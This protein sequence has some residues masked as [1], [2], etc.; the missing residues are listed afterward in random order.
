M[1]TDTRS[2]IL[3]A[4]GGSF[5]IEARQPAEVFTPED[6]SDE[7]RMMG[8]TAAEFMEKELVPRLPR[9]LALDYAATREVL[10]KAGELGLLG[11]EI[12][13]EY[14][15]LGL[16]KVSGCLVSEKSARDG[17]FSVTFMGHIG[18]G[19]LPIVYFGTEEQK[20]RYLPK[21]ASGEWIGSYSLSEASSASDAMNAKARAVLS[22]DGRHWILN[23][24]KMWLTNAGYAD[25]YITFCKV[26]GEHFTAFIIDKG[27]PGVSLGAEEKK[28][29]L[30][31]SSTR[32]LILQDAKIPKQNLLGEI[33]K[34]HKIAFNILNVGR[35]KLGA[36]CTGA[37]KLALKTSAEYAK[38]RIAFGK[39]IAEFGLIR[40]KLGEMAIRTFV[41]ESVVYRTA[42]MI[43]ENL[44]GVGLHDA[45]QALKRIEE[46]DVECSIVKVFAS[47]MLD[48]VVDE[49]VQLFGG[50]GFVKDY[51]AERYWRDARVN[52][53]FE[54]TNE[55]NRLLIP[56]RLLRRVRRNE[57]DLFGA[58]PEPGGAQGPLAAERA[59]LAAIKRLACE[60]LEAADQR[61][62]ETLDDQQEAL[63]AFADLA[64]EAY[65][66]ES[67][68]VRATKGAPGARRDRQERAVR[69]WA[70][71]AADRASAAARRLLSAAGVAR[72]RSAWETLAALTG[73]PAVDATGLRRELADA[74]VEQGGY[75]LS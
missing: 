40:H 60:G 69:C 18:I 11:I 30:E 55:I 42:G 14:G 34:G 36:G 39:P 65:A 23:G 22:D 37:A 46:Y 53:I 4:R 70:Q 43:D 58:D 13:E 8:E 68:L 41:T 6:F 66:L 1:A 71:D 75:P 47:E 16:D 2:P 5:L 28:T 12:P 21:M 31:G 57:L 26:D 72:D 48:W 62:G 17:S 63:A 33:G 52:R 54:G 50:A 7:Q 51:P 67:A 59:L 29:G 64:I 74:A 44:K 49:T 45:Q 61:F 10:A 56:G 9:T 35:F 24:E 32:P 38:S 15:G 25:V 20:R 27:S 3:A 73:R 19:T